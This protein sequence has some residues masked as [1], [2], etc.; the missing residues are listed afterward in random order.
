MTHLTVVPR[1]APLPR[2]LPHTA[3]E[4]ADAIIRDEYMVQQL[5]GCIELWCQWRDIPYDAETPLLQIG[6]DY[7]TSDYWM[8]EID[9]LSENCPYVD[10]SSL[11]IFNLMED[12]YITEQ[13][14]GDR[15]LLLS[16]ALLPTV[17]D[18]YRMWLPR[19]S[20]FT[21]VLFQLELAQKLHPH[22]NWKVVLAESCLHAFVMD[23]ETYE[24]FDLLIDEYSRTHHKVGHVFDTPADYIE[25]AEFIND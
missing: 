18:D 20:C 25:A 7:T 3:E 9:E 4:V 1:T 2:V 17:M 12:G 14:A 5:R 15:I 13:E 10:N 11:E 24:I 16:E 6:R 23:E 8:R 21:S 19:H 22:K